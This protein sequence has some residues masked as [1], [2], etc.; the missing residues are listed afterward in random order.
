MRDFEI[1]FWTL[2]FLAWM[3]SVIVFWRVL[4]FGE[5]LLGTLAFFLGAMA[6]WALHTEEVDPVIVD[7]KPRRKKAQGALDYLIIIAA[8][9]AI[10]AVV[11]LFITGA[12]NTNTKLGWVSHY[13]YPVYTTYE[14]STDGLNAWYNNEIKSCG[15]PNGFGTTNK[16]EKVDEFLV[17]GTTYRA[18]EF[19]CGR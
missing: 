15:T 16:F 18:Y 12:F 10:A 1:T 13:T 2:A 6:I 4:N 17:N 5:G 3:V 19:I 7:T 8:V 9:L 11:V 14:R